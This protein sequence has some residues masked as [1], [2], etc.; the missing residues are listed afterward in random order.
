M[1]PDSQM[2]TLSMYIVF[3]KKIFKDNTKTF[4]EDH[5]KS[6]LRWVAVNESIEKEYPDYIPN[7]CIIKEWEMPIYSPLYQMLQFYQNSTFLHIYWNKLHEQTKYTG[8]AQYDMSIDAEEILK[9]ELSM[10]SDTAD[11]L[12]VAFPYNEKA[13]SQYPDEYWMDCFI[14][15]YNSFYHQCHTLESVK[16]VPVF[17]LHTFIMPSWFFA[18]MMPFI[19][20]S[21][22]KILRSLSW[23]TRHL[24]GTLERIFALCLSCA[25]LEGKFR[26]IVQLNG[27]KTDIDG[28]RDADAFRGIP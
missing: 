5:M 28:Q 3:H 18:H 8:F 13:L 2:K 9:Y 10:T 17:L 23:N 12:F 24:A 20:K 6:S 16:K 22:P 4:H 19:E 27:I 11:T 15:P 26:K 7:E 1:P 25:V 21:I 14:N